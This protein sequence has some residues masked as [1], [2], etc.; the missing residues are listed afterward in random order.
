MNDNVTEKINDK[1]FKILVCID[2]SDDSYR[3]L[4]YAARIGSGSD[5]DIT[6]LYIRQADKELHTGGLDMRVARENMLDWG[7][8]LPGMQALKRGRDMLTEMGYL[9]ED[10]RSQTSHTEIH[11][12]PLGDNTV[13][14]TSGEGR[15]VIL[16]LKVATSPELGILDES[17]IGEYNITIV[18]SSNPGKPGGKGIRYGDSVSQVVATE[19]NNTVIVA[20]SL[21]ENHGHLL[22]VSGSSSSYRAARRDAMIA[23]RCYCPIY[24]YSVATD[25]SDIVRSQGIIDKARKIIEDAGYGVSGE[26]IDVGDP[27]E[28]I[29][30]E[31]RHYS[32][33][34]L[35]GEPRRGLWRFF[36]S[37]MLYKVLDMAHNSVMI[38][39]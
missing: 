18:S 20:N 1:P 7:L 36:K 26:K 16:K 6:L 24:L 33:I 38:S 27:I 37:K 9:D 32:L 5:A 29:V 11:G 28:R 31:G 22:C 8:E 35:S 15:K 3:G 34:V 2:G 23:S 10:W 17:E 39:R 12:D 25:E 19:S 14:Y 4:R 30:E 21:E 13:E